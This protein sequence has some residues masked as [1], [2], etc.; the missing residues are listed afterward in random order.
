MADPQ[1]LQDFTP[2]LKNVYLPIRKKI[3][4]I[5]TVLLAQARK[6]GP[7]HVTYAGNDLFFDV[8]VE[9]RGGFVSSAAGFLPTSRIAREKQG[10]LSVARTYAKVQVDGLALK[11]TNDSKGSYISAAKKIVEDVMDQWEIEQERILHSDSL[12][13]RAVVSSVTNTTTIVANAPYGITSGGI[14]NLHLVDGDDVAV[15]N[16]TTFALRGKSSIASHTVSG[17]NATF[18]LTVAIAGMQANDVIVTCVP[19]SVDATDTSFGAEPHGLKSI[20]DVENSF[21]TFEGLNDPR[22]VANKITSTTVDETIVMKLLNTIRARAGVDWRKSPKNMLLLTSTG[23]WQAYGESLLGLRRFSAP[24]QEL[25]GGFTGVQVANAT[26]V[27][28]PWAPRGRLYAVHGPDT[29]FVD[30]MDFGEVSFQDAPKW[31]RVSNR[32][33]WEAVFASYW[34]YGVLNRLSHGVISGI[35][36]TVNYSPVFA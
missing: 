3:F 7:E 10:R 2:V 21:A 9:R 17:D 6:L 4:P 1:I 20:C 27:D 11:A 12:G 22:W 23:I 35:T 18:T 13:I 33:A 16:G 26:L 19:S 14:G 31:Q 24:T 5:N 25:K 36:D 8:K 29:V 34:N 32:D 15:L 28:D 30:L